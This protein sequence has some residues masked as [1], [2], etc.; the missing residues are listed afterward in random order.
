MRLKLVTLIIG[1]AA[2]A[3]VAIPALAAPPNVVELGA[4]LKGKEE[5]P[6]PGDEKGTGEAQ[7]EVK[8]AKLKVCYLI[9]YDLPSGTATAAHIHKG[10]KGVAGK[11]VVE[12]FEGEQQSPAED[13]VKVEKERKLKKIVKNPGDFYVNVHNEQFPDGAIRGQLKVLG[14]GPQ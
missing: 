3:A 5:V 2:F 9:E 1:T 8:V 6:G 4:K 12:L 14:T 13:C 11:I 10:A 7:L